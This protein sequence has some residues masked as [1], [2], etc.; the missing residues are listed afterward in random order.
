M[1]RR[2]LAGL[3]AFLCF[4]EIRSARYQ[5]ALKTEDDDIILAESAVFHS[6]VNADWWIHNY[7]PKVEPERQA[8]LNCEWIL[9]DL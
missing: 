1:I 4:H 9:V 2:I 7:A 8:R 5:A 3:D 6:L